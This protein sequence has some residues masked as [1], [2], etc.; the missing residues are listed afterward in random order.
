MTEK[1]IRRPLDVPPFIACTHEI[2]AEPFGFF[3]GNLLNKMSFFFFIKH[4]SSKLNTK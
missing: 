3:D 1:T 2:T 4:H